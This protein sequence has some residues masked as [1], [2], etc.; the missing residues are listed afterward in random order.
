MLYCPFA[1]I[2]RIFVDLRYEKFPT[3]FVK[4]TMPMQAGVTLNRL[5]LTTKLTLRSFA[6]RE[7]RFNFQLHC[8]LSLSEKKKLKK[9]HSRPAK[10]HFVVISW[11]F[12][13]ISNRMYLTFS[14]FFSQTISFPLLNVII[15]GKENYYILVYTAYLSLCI[16]LV[17]L[18]VLFLTRNHLTVRRK[19]QI[20]FS[21][22]PIIFDIC[23]CPFYSP[24]TSNDRGGH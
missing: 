24:P 3:D 5:E 7:T 11:V 19:Y 1:R 13:F 23:F 15:F 12:K 22:S 10:I 4:T 8:F 9:L 18:L 16:F 2:L 17:L 14:S 21:F 6:A 20:F